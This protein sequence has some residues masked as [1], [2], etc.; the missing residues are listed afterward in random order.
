MSLTP[1]SPVALRP[2]RTEGT[3]VGGN[4]ALLAAEL[5]SGYEVPAADSVVVLEDTNEPLYRV[6]RLLTQLLRAGWFD[7]VRGVALG[8][9]VGGASDGS[10]NDLVVERLG[11]LGVP[12]VTGV[13]V[14]HGPRNLAFPL[15]VPAVLDAEEGALVTSEAPLR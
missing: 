8:E 1:E 13:P 12:I 14:G 7:G 11:P 3:L 4:L 15:G 2:G 9:F 10:V 6:D 5:G